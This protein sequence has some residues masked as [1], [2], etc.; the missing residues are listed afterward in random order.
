MC[1]FFKYLLVSLWKNQSH[2]I[3]FHCF[4]I[5]KCNYFRSFVFTLLIWIT[6]L[7]I[8][9]SYIRENI[10]QLLSYQ[11]YISRVAEVSIK[12]QI[13]CDSATSQCGR[14]RFR[15]AAWL[16]NYTLW[17]FRAFPRKY[18]SKSPAAM[19]WKFPEFAPGEKRIWRRG[20]LCGHRLTAVL[21]NPISRRRVH[22][23]FN[24]TFHWRWKSLVT[25]DF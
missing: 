14:V 15:M 25:R 7:L 1:D 6:V 3:R 17:C 18:V 20:I 19:S 5:W 22:A 24:L 8:A 11:N 9:K 10:I 21:H 23:E 16:V 2:Q 4:I 13:C 12:M